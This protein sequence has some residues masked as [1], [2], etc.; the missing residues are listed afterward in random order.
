MK[1]RQSEIQK[2][3]VIGFVPDLVPLVISGEKTLT[4]RL[5][6]NY[7][8]DILQPGD[9]V[10][11][12]NSETE[13]TFAELEIVDKS[14]TTFGNLP[15]DAEEHER[16]SSKEEQRDTFHKYYNREI[17]DDERIII[18][19]FKISKLLVT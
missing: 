17:K 10:K 16:Y 18:L 12:I 2:D 13:E 1:R 7:N 8:Y 3:I 14:Y 9:L 6:D 11:T 4:Y 19:E 5:E 15:L